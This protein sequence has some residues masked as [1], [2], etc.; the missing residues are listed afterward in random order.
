MSDD[1]S[2]LNFQDDYEEVLRC[3]DARRWT[4]EKPGPLEIWAKLS[5]IGTPAEV[6]QVRW[7]WS[8]YPDDPPSMK[9][10][11]PATGRLDVATAWPEVRGF[12]P[13]TFDACVNW[14]SEG[15]VLHPEWKND[16][17]FRWTGS[18]NAL[19]KVLRTLQAELDDHFQ[20]RFRQ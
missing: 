14:C 19:L 13:P 9:F 20:R 10:R 18:G 12:R 11:D 1:L 15:F 8:R 6:F 2:G 4:L 17:K 3:E 5:P 7:L 16:P